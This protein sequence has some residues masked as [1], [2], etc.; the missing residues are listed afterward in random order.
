MPKATGTQAAD[1]MSA[2]SG[3]AQV[4]RAGTATFSAWEPDTIVATTRWPTRRSS[5]P[6]PTSS[7][8][9]AHW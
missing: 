3:T 4:T 2:P 9:P 7:I 1:T 8:V 5:T 6:G